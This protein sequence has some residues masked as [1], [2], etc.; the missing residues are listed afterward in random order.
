M[1]QSA[2]DL[3][4]GRSM[5]MSLGREGRPRGGSRVVSKTPKLGQAD[6]GA[7]TT[8]SELGPGQL[9]IARPLALGPRRSRERATVRFVKF[10]GKQM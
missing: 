2:P 10:G 7:S 3:S 9:V 4:M 8:Q 5:S 1:Y 6:L